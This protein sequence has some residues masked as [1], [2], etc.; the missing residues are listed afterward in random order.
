MA[1]IVT[2]Y[3]SW[4]RHFRLQDMSHIRWQKISEALAKC[5][6]QVDMATNEFQGMRWWRR[7]SPIHMAKN[8]RR[9]PLCEVRWG[10]YDVVKTLFHIG[11]ET[12]QAYGG[13]DHPFIISKLGSVVGSGDRDGIYFYGEERER[14][15]STQR[16]IHQTSRYITVL[17]ESAK[18]LWAECFGLRNNML[19]VPGG[20][21]RSV[22][23]PSHDPYRGERKKRCIFAGNI[24]GKGSQPE[25]NSALVV[26]LNRLGKALSE[27][28]VRLY[29]LGPGDVRKLD[30]RYVTYLGVVSYEDTWDYLYFA[31]VGVVVSAGT[32]MHNNESSKIYH[33]LRVGLPVVSE[34]GFPN[35]QVVTES[36]LGCVV[37]NANVDLMARKIQEAA[38]KHW[39]RDHAINYILSNHTWDKRVEIYD[40][41][42]ENHFLTR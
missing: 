5:G 4:R 3:T 37:E 27:R 38:E 13:Q 21:D 29:M 11:F 33:Y 39:N 22:P 20:V 24:Y 41:I 26:K 2:V 7:I 8:V 31:D 30:K 25:A 17:N 23:P 34:A 32:F 6:H 35:D 16:R 12:L 15:Y 28:N 10:D 1:R 9:V 14:L 42:I 19:I 36:G 18:D 40:T